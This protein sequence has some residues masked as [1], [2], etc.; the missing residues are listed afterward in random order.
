MGLGAY[1]YFTIAEI[2]AT[3]KSEKVWAPVAMLYDNF[4]FWPAV[5]LLPAIGAFSLYQAMKAY[6]G[7]HAPRNS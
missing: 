6:Q 3:G 7:E 5:L 4:G 1:T 2:E